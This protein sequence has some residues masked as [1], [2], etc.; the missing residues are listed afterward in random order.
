[1]VQGKR[2]ALFWNEAIEYP[3]SDGKPMA[4][5]T[6]Q[7]DLIV[8]LHTGLR[9]LFRERE[10][11][12]IVSDLLWYPVE[13]H[14][15]ICTAPDVMVAFG[16]PAGDR[17]SYRQWEEGDTPPQIVIEVLSSSN[18]VSEML[19]KLRFFE[20]YGVEEFYILDPYTPGIELFV[21]EGG[22][23]VPVEVSQS[24]TVARLGITFKIEDKN[25]AIYDTGGQAFLSPADIKAREVEQRLEADL[26]RQLA[27]EQRLI[28][29]EQRMLAD[30]QR[31]LAEQERAARLQAEAEIER[32]RRLLDK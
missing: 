13:G 9:Y 18:R 8:K 29:D 30:E 32:L 23:L 20:T 4:D 5:N 12:L 11:V 27:A 21:R 14:P 31:M 25:I 19:R 3:D 1:M 28:A 24:W 22:I 7:F 26:Q 10:D 2:P 15:E 6:I 17:R 16:R